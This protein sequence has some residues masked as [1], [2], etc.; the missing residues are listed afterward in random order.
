[1]AHC[2]TFTKMTHV[3]RA[4]CERCDGELIFNGETFDLPIKKYGHTCAK[5]GEKSL[6]VKTHPYQYITE[7]EE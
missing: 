3:V 1:M 7:E 5:C 4:Y 6:L 2:K